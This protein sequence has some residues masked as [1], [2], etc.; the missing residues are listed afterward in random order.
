MLIRV[1][2]VAALIGIVGVAIGVVGFWDGQH[3]S[4]YRRM[5]ARYSRF[6]SPGSS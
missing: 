5:T 3:G 1:A 2:P 4:L 6:Q